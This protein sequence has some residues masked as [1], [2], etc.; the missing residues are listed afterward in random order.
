M[1]FPI[2]FPNQLQGQVTVRLQLLA[3]GL[4]IGGPGLAPGCR[5][6]WRAGQHFFQPAL[7][8]VRGQGPTHAGDRGGFQVLMDSA[9]G[10]QTTAGNLLLFEPQGMESQNFF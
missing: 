4:E 9:L 1:I 6:P 5:R 7:L 10:D 2:F 8:K 3:D